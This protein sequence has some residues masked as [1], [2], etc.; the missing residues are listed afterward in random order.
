MDNTK[1]SVHGV[2]WKHIEAGFSK[3]TGKAYGAFSVCPVTDC[4]E[5]PTTLKK[6]EP[7]DQAISQGPQVNDFVDA[8]KAV[9]DRSYRIERQHSQDMAL[10]FFQARHMDDFTDQMLKDRT[11]M[12]MADLDKKPNDP[13][14][15]VEMIGELKKI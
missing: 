1:C 5:R 14:A 12:F 15:N 7:I 11:D 6:D 13:I 10:R 8:T 4:K 2:E 3:K 9:A